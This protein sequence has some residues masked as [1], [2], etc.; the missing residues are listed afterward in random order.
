M[1]EIEMDSQTAAVRLRAAVQ[2][3]PRSNH[4]A[5][6]TINHICP[7]TAQLGHRALS[8]RPGGQRFVLDRQLA[9]MFFCVLVWRAQASPHP[10]LYQSPQS[11]THVEAEMLD[12]TRRS[13]RLVT[14]LTAGP[15]IILAAY[16]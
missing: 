14:L 15:E 7:R 12:Q 13:V 9:E 5:W 4:T 8:T 2:R 6:T 16:F 1:S 3:D 11:P 10:Y